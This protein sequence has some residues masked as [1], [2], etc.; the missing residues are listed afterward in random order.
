M[1]SIIIPA[2]KAENFIEE[3]LDSIKGQTYFIN[4]PEYEIL[5]GID[6]CITTL[7]KIA[8]ISHNYNNLKLFYFNQNVGPYIIKNTLIDYAKYE[9]IL[10]FDA[11]DIMKSYL[12]ETAM[13]DKNSYDIVRIRFVNFKDSANNQTPGRTADGIFL[14]KKDKF[15][16][17][18]GFSGWRCAADTDFHNR[19]VRNNYKANHIQTEL[20]LRRM[21]DNNL[22]VQS[23]TS[24]NSSLR[25]E[26]K[27]Q[28]DDAKKHH[29]LVIYK[30]TNSNF[31]QL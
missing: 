9:N 10:F 17:I 15:N 30:Q 22:T 2:Y 16:N 7:H 3:C 4:H 11:D 25:N 31:L 26:Y 5:I 27:K 6:C 23:S 20:F 8:S 13:Y 14:I 19:T 12:V 24:F 1:V 28:I 29:V 21:H 18:G